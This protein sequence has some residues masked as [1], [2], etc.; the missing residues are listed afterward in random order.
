M[1]FWIQ[2]SDPAVT[3][4]FD[5]EDETL[6][7]ALQVVFPLT[8]EY[9]ILNWNGVLVPLD[10]KYELSLMSLDLLDMLDR[11]AESDAGTYSNAWLPNGFRCDWTLTWAD[12]E[13]TVAAD[14]Q[15]IARGLERQLQATGDVTLPVAQFRREWKA[16]LGRFSTALAAGG[17]QPD[18]IRGMTDLARIHDGIDRPGALYHPALLP[19]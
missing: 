15:I 16:V 4:E 17:Y 7:E 8:T 18:R 5:P 11:L 10:Y 14:W 12:R 2:A 19:L 1:D 13:L 9:A 3:G 6:E